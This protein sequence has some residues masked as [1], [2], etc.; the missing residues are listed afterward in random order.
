VVARL[1][2]GAVLAAILALP[3]PADAAYPGRDGLIAFM[4]AVGSEPGQIYVVRPNGRGLRQITHRRLGAGSPT[5]SPDGR[6]IAFAG[7]TKHGVH[8]FV[9]RLG[10]RVWQITRGSDIWLAP[11]WSPDGRW[12]AAV[13]KDF[14]GADLYESIVAMRR[15]GTRKRV[16]YDGGQRSTMEPA[17]SPDGTSIAF[18]H[19]DVDIKGA[20]PNIYVVPRRG[21]EAR[22]ITGVGLQEGP[23][24]SPDGSLIAYSWGYYNLSYDA[25][26][27]LRPDGTGEAPVTDAK[28]PAW[29][30]SGTRLAISRGGQIWTVKPDGSRL[31]RVTDI[32]AENVSHYD[33]TWQPR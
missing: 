19:N 16:L 29:A 2:V 27:V 6:R 5:W 18:V 11:T 28:D 17:W 24:W 21:G 30:P 31:R 33:P 10:G 12:I 3:S 14:E 1:A 20:D 26:H 23:D 7:M 22:R 25:V 8:I 9:K 32:E 15:D 4:R 13:R